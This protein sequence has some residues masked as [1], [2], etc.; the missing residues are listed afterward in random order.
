MKTKSQKLLQASRINYKLPKNQSL[1][2]GQSLKNKNKI[3]AQKIGS[4]S[5]RMKQDQYIISC[6]LKSKWITDLNL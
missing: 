4:T 5:K 2:K 1:E 3:S 6:T